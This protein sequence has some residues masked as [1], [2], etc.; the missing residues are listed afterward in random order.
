MTQT[1]DARPLG[2]WQAFPSADGMGDR[3]VTDM[4]RFIEAADALADRAEPVFDSEY[5]NTRH[6]EGALPYYAANREALAAYRAA[7]E[8]ITRGTPLT[9]WA[10]DPNA[11][12]EDDE[13][14][15]GRDYA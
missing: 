10:N 13:I 14:Q 5:Y 8:A 11:I 7:R 1:D 2:P 9:N 6:L 4:E 12:V 3:G 15:I